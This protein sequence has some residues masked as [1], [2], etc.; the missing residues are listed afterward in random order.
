MEKQSCLNSDNTTSSGILVSL[1]WKSNLVLILTI[2]HLVIDYLN[3]T[4]SV[5]VTSYFTVF[6]IAY[7]N[8]HMTMPNNSVKKGYKYLFK[9][10]NILV[11]YQLL[12]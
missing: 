1:I 3:I 8:K 7:H 10:N 12:N 4:N 6:V 11:V 2:L 9:S 5:Q